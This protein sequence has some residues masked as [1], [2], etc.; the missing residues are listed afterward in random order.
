MSDNHWNIRIYTFNMVSERISNFF[1]WIVLLNFFFYFSRLLVRN[2]EFHLP[3][4]QN[5]YINEEHSN[6]DTPAPTPTRAPWNPKYSS[7]SSSS[8]PTPTKNTH[9]AVMLARH[10]RLVGGHGRDR[11]HKGERNGNK[12]RMSF[13]FD[14]Q[15]G[16]KPGVGLMCSHCGEMR[17]LKQRCYEII[18][19]PDWWD[20]KKKTRKNIGKS[21][22]N[23]IETD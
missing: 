10:H 21:V 7:S 11:G 23:L 5:T 20:F 15:P 16:Y 19:Y 14:N 13:I 4:H 8:T 3:T 1:L 18:G 2:Q 17:H 12:G 22:V 6:N 9:H